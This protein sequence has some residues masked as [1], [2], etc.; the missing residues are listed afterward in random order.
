MESN[1]GAKKFLFMKCEEKINKAFHMSSNWLFSVL[2]N[3]TVSTSM[4]SK[5]RKAYGG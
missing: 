4:K 1:K 2:Y 3:M 5:F